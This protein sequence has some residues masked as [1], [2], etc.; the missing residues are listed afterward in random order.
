MSR[1]RTT[2]ETLGAAFRPK[3]SEKPIGAAFSARREEPLPSIV[4]LHPMALWHEVVA[5][6]GWPQDHTDINRAVDAAV[7][8][9]DLDLSLIE[10]RYGKGAWE[11]T[12][13]VLFPARE[14]EQDAPGVF[15]LE[16]Q[17]KTVRLVPPKEAG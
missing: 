2:K 10:A 4:V 11:R 12:P 1:A 7:A 5:R 16:K 3:A 14:G 9:G 13:M 8:A 6:H 17:G 15:R